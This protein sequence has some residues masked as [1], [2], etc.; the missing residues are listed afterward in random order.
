MH[1]DFFRVYDGE[2][3]KAETFSAFQACDHADRVAAR[4]GEARIVFVTKIGEKPCNLPI[5]QKSA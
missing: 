4:G 2:T 5:R 3:I 1:N